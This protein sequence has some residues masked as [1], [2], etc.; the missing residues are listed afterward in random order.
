MDS[1]PDPKWR[2][3][4][5]WALIIGPVQFVAAMALEEALRPGYSPISNVISDL[6][7]GSYSIIF[8]SSVMLLGLLTIFGIAFMQVEFPRNLGAGLG[9]LT[10]ILVGFGAIGVGTFPEDHPV[11]HF[12]SA[13]VAFLGAGLA[14]LFYS[15]SFRRDLR[16]SR[17]TIPTF[18]GGLFT[19]AS[20]YLY[21]SSVLGKDVTGLTERC[22]VVPILI[23]APAVGMTILATRNSA[24]VSDSPDED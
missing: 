11:P 13:L 23:W 16:W 2:T 12:L 9:Y 3:I 4:G 10:L 1:H 21:V 15:M 8:N 14:L 5:A 7:V 6:G 20:I 19:L 17:F 24:S 22:I 18:V